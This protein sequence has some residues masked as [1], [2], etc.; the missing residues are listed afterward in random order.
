MLVIQILGTI[1]RF[2][3]NAFSRRS[4]S[5]SAIARFASAHHADGSSF[6]HFDLPLTKL[7][8]SLV[9]LA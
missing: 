2:P 9:I 1:P 4:R 7:G 3:Q 6:V 5:G 8:P